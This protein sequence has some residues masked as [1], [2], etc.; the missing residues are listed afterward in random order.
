MAGEYDSSKAQ[1]SYNKEQLMKWIKICNN[2]SI[3]V[4]YE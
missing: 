2:T 1:Q 3:K 4:E